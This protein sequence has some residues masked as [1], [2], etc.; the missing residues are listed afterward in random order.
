M[1]N[2]LFRF[3]LFF[4][5]AIMAS[6]TLVPPAHQIPDNN[7]F[8]PEV[9]Y[10]IPPVES[11]TLATM[12]MKVAKDE[13][14]CMAV[15]AKGFK[16]ILTMQYSMNWDPAIL[17]FKYFKTFGLKGMDA[18]NFG[19]HLLDKGIL[20]FSWYDQ[21]LVG[22][23]HEDGVEL[24]ELCFVAVGEKGSETSLEIS[25]KP[26]VVEIANASSI[27]LDLRTDTGKIKIK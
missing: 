10:Q 24:Y 16:D 23:S 1:K 18:R 7:R 4:C 19:Q 15:S 9:I 2:K 14:V 11:L 27:F 3:L 5:I 13:E 6:F 26:T 12:D 17:K 20:T 25:S 8:V 21:N 22:I